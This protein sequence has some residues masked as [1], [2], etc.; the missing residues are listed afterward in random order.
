MPDLFTPL[1]VG[2]LRLPNRVLMAPLTRCR[3]TASRVPNDLMA[4]HYRQRAG[5]GLIISEATAISPEALGYP[6]TPGIFT[7]EQVG[8]WKRVTAAVHGAG[9]RIVCQLWHVGR[10]SHPAYQPHGRA[11]VAPSAVDPGGEC[12]LPDGSKAARVEPRAMTLDD[13]ALTIRDYAHAASAAIEAGFDG[14]EVHGA[15]GYLPE[16]FL[17]DGTNRRTDAYGGPVEN[18]ARFLLEA[19][20]ACVDVC[21][22]ERVGVRLS[23]SGLS[24]AGGGD[25]DHLATYGHVVRELDAMGVA[26]LHIMEAVPGWKTVSPPIPVRTFRS[27]YRGVLI[28]NGGFDFAK[29]TRYVG[30]GWCD[31]V[32]FGTLYIANP[33]LAERF[34][35]YGERA[36]LNAPDPATYYTPGAR[37]YCDYPTMGEGVAALPAAEGR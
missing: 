28:T 31:A 34:A 30:E 12:R 3:A 32:A 8:G 26:F 33:D 13:I 20:G 22:A 6:E 2:P 25:S 21:G 27:M 36:P 16:Q 19:T 17:R 23:P 37:G 1:D 10:I 24:G 35:R 9:G 11:P 18:R 5:S 15:N 4:E 29:A 14:V 7:A